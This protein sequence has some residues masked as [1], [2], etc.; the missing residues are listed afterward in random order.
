[1]DKAEAQNSLEGIR[2][3]LILVLIGILITPIRIGLMLAQ[4]HIPMFSDGTWSALTSPSSESYHHLWGPLLAFE[5][6]GNIAVITLALITLLFFL[7][8]SRHTPKIAI[9]WLLSGFV[10]VVADYFLA[11][12]IPA[13]AEIATDA[14]TFKEVARSTIGVLI[15]VP[16]FLVSKRV[17]ATFIR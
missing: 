11:E 17:K 10:F 13:I 6:A 12:Q 5:M 7:R 1:M 9:I 4:T 3:W 8:K 15:W 16:Y 14:E 2:G